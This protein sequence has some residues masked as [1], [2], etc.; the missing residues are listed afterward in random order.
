MRHKVKI[1][2]MKREY[3]QDLADEFLVDPQVGKCS[4]FYEGQE[5]MVDQSEYYTFTHD[6]KFC[7]AAWDTIK[8]KVYAG[9]QGGRFFREGWH[10]DTSKQI[11]C[12]DDGVRPVVFLLERIDLED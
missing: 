9:L 4:K 7:Q 5:F 3:Y 8:E 12:C 1:T 10:K 2:V 6:G 11:L